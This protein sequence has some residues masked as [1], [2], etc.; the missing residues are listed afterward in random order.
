MVSCR[1]AARSRSGQGTRPDCALT[2]AAANGLVRSA[3]DCSDGGLAVTL[4]GVHFD[5]GGIGV[6]ADLPREASLAAALFG[7]SAA[8]AV[9]SVGA[10]NLQAL[11]RLAREIGV[12]ARAI[13]RTGGSRITMT[14]DGSP[15]I[16]SPVAEAEQVW[17][18]ALGRYSRV[19]QR[20][21]SHAL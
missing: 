8:R 19:G 11:L 7:E 1:A 10:G 3:H 6:T 16:D 17:T 2:Q 20:R 14:V 12:P 9:V 15:S 21:I 13:G 5:T 18:S 4:A